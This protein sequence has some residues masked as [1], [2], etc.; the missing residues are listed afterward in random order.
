MIETI[1]ICLV[2]VICALIQ[3]PRRTP[4]QTPPRTTENIWQSIQ[5][6]SFTRRGWFVLLVELA[7]IA[8]VL[9]EV[10]RPG[11]LTKLSVYKIVVGVALFFFILIQAAISQG[12]EALFLM[13]MADL[14]LMRRHLKKEQRGE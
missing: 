3:S 8:Y 7:L 6:S 2:M 10:L 9:F 1:L 11:E 12:F 5:K 14:D 13:K 4:T